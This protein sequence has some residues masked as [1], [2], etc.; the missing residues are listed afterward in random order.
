MGCNR[1]SDKG[2][3]KFLAG[4]ILKE[5]DKKSKDAGKMEKSVFDLEEISLKDLNLLSGLSIQK[6]A[7]IIGNSPKFPKLTTLNLSGVNTLFTQRDVAQQLSEALAK[8]ATLKEI[9]LA[10]TGLG[11]VSQ[12]SVVLLADALADLDLQILDLS[13]NFIQYEG[14]K[15][16]A[17]VFED[18]LRLREFYL[19]HNSDKIRELEVRGI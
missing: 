1:F 3:S 4:F 15:A 17:R 12:H 5:K 13:G 14:F 7:Q 8:A 16:L 10:D 19:N 18:K 9:R 11:L 2:F 6:L